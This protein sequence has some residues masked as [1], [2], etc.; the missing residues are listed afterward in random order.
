MPYTL[1]APSVWVDFAS[2]WST[3]NPDHSWTNPEP[4]QRSKEL[5]VPLRRQILEH[6]TV[7]WKAVSSPLLYS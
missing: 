4:S 7:G 1:P 6:R 3:E 2:V 5:S